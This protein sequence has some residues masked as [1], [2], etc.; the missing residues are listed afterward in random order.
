MWTVWTTLHALTA[1]LLSCDWCA[2]VWLTYVSWL[3]IMTTVFKKVVVKVC[4]EGTCHVWWTRHVR[5]S[6]LTAVCAPHY[7]IRTQTSTKLT[8]M[9]S[10]WGMAS[11]GLWFCIHWVRNYSLQVTS[12]ASPFLWIIHHWEEYR[13][14]V[15]YSRRCLP[16]H[17][18]VPSPPLL[19]I[20]QYSSTVM[21]WV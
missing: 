20:H 2:L 5:N 13:L 19:H 15:I 9:P 11:D 16:V 21:F 17:T 10:L 8:A 6:A 4:L 7:N 3:S 1:V 18:T 14:C 12:L